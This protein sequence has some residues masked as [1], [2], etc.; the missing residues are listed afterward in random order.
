MGRIKFYESVEEMQADLNAFL[1]TYNEKRPHQG[2]NI[3]GRTPKQVFLSGL[4]KPKKSKEEKSKK[5]A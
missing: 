2:L 3:N 5:A 4:P 1:Q